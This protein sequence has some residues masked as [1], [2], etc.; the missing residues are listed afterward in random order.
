MENSKVFV[1][2]HEL[3]YDL[4]F[5]ITSARARNACTNPTSTMVAISQ[6]NILKTKIDGPDVKRYATLHRQCERGFALPSVLLIAI[7]ISLL[8]VTLMTLARVLANDGSALASGIG[9]RAA[10]EAGLNRI[11]LAFSRPGDPLRESLVP[12]SRPVAWEFH[13]GT[14]LLRA[15]AESGKLDLNAADRA[16]AASA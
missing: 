12:D 11:I 8:S 13:G 9:A 5:E 7:L 3:K 4:L 10:T 16:Y 2:R 6:T 1:F 15:Q 14:L